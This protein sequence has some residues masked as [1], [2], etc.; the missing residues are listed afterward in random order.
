MAAHAVNRRL[1]RQLGFTMIEVM[2]AMLLTVIATTGIIALYIVNTRASGF[3]RH[4]T[5]ATMLAQDQIE[6]L[7]L[8]SVVPDSGSVADLNE[9]GVVVTGVGLFTRAYAVTAGTADYDSVVVTV[10]W[11]EEGKS[12][13]VALRSRRNK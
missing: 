7:R 12:K 6:R 13:N 1:R 3:S 2:V 5:E 4:A 11:I 8:S 10:T 9:Q